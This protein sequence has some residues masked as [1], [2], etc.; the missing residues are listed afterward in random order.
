M[1]TETV[2]NN[3]SEKM[4]DAKPFPLEKILTVSARDYVASVN[5]SGRL[6]DYEM[7]GVHVETN[8]DI[9][10]SS[11]VESSL[12]ELFSKL[13]PED[14]EVVVD[15]RTSVAV[16]SD[17]ISVYFRKSASGTALIPK[18]KEPVDLEK[19]RKFQAQE[20]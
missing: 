16:A 20:K 6:S 3:S 5:G 7:K 8:Q 17:E 14:A 12:V 4:T 18:T 2:R 1:Q 10:S 15:Y 9:R 11:L 13:V 19:F